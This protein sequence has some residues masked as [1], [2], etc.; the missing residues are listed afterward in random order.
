LR[1]AIENFKSLKRIE[2]E[3]ADA[4]V[5]IGAPASGK[6]NILDAI[7]FAGLLPQVSCLG[8]GVRE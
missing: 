2:M 8:R 1:I 6:S 3:L 4:T 7:A 5:L